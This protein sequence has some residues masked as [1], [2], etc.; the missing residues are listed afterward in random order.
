MRQAG[1]EDEAAELRFNDGKLDFFRVSVNSYFA[2]VAADFL[3]QK[4][5]VQR[6][7]FSFETV[8]SAPDKVELLTKA[9]QM[10]YRHAMHIAGMRC[11]R[12]IQVAVGV[13]PDH[14]EP[15]TL[16]GEVRC[17]AGN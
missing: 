13:D 1:L 10:G 6:T 7:S 11:A 3:R 9:Q 15:F 16:G 4:L 17:G 5:L 12:R 2:S 8:M 14:A